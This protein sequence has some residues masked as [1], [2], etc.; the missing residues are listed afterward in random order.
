MTQRIKFV[1]LLALALG[2]AW[3]IT[4]KPQPANASATLPL[5][6]VSPRAFSKKTV[7]PVTMRAR[8]K[9]ALI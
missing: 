2:T 7:W 3:V 8:K 1:V 5:A 4:P 6:A 9:A